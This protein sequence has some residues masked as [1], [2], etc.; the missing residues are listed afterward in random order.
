MNRDEAAGRLPSFL[1]NVAV[2][3]SSGFKTRLEATPTQRQEIAAWCDVPEI[4][5]LSADLVIKRWR[6]DG[7]EVSGVVNAEVTQPCI[8]TLEPVTQTVGEKLSV[9]LVQ[10]GSKLA[11]PERLLDGELVIDPDGPDVPEQYTGDEIDLWPVVIEFLNLAIDRYPRKEGV[12]LDPAYAPDPQVSPET[13]SP[14][15]GLS[16]ML[17]DSSGKKDT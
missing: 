9:T 12:E 2:L 6:R 8:V 15:S 14:F 3:P 7:V 5:S 16:G 1:L 11:R 13:R 17:G 4:D 10:A